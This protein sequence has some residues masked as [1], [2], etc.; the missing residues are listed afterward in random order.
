MVGESFLDGFWNLIDD[1]GR[2][3]DVAAGFVVLFVCS[4]FEVQS[5]V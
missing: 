2:I 4:V 5:D 1:V 3:L